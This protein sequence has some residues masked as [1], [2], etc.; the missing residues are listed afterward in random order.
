MPIRMTSSAGNSN[1]VTSR[2]PRLAL[3]RVGAFTTGWQVSTVMV[4]ARTRFAL[5][6]WVYRTLFS[7]SE[8]HLPLHSVSASGFGHL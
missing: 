2:E 7:H 6:H 4:A 8:P 3:P 5:L 1:P